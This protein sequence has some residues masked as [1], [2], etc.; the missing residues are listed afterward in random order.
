MED[1][2]EEKVLLV[3]LNNNAEAFCGILIILCNNIILTT[4]LRYS[5]IDEGEDL[6]NREVAFGGRSP[7]LSLRNERPLLKCPPMAAQP[8]VSP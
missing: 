3:T 8:A 5:M 4:M 1:R 2:P 7:L 6:S